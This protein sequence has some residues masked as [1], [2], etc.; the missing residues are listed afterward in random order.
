MKFA[1]LTQEVQI[2]KV[3]VNKP[4]V[5]LMPGRRMANLQIKESLKSGNDVIGLRGILLTF[6]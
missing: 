3:Q 2:A 1:E 4:D 5:G 6:N